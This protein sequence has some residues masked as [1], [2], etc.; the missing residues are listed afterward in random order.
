MADDEHLVRDQLPERI[1]DR[2]DDPVTHTVDGERHQELLVQRAHAA[3]IAYE[4]RDQVEHLADVLEVVYTLAA[5][6]GVDPEA[7]EATRAE[8]AERNGG[9]QEGVVLDRV[10]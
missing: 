5:N 3:L 4:D 10:D 9:F 2:G 6:D 1:S 7:L 8:R